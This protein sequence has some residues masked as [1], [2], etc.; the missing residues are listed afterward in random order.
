MAKG[1]YFNNPN[2][3]RTCGCGESFAVLNRQ[4][5]IE[6]KAFQYFCLKGFIILEFQVILLFRRRRWLAVVWNPLKCFR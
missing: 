4:R 3:T 6:D 5:K 2:A 1:F